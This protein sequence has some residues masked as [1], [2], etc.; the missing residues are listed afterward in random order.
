MN[1]LMSP[2]VIELGAVPCLVPFALASTV[3]H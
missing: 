2:A 1:E 3:Y